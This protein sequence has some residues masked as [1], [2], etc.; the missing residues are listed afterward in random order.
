[1]IS[2]LLYF[3]FFK[4]NFDLQETNGNIDNISV[5]DLF[6]KMDGNKLT[7]TENENILLK[8]L[9]NNEN[10]TSQT[11]IP[12]NTVELE[13]ILNAKGAL[14]ND[15]NSYNDPFDLELAQN[16]RKSFHSMENL[17]SS[18]NFTLNLNN[19]NNTLNNNIRPLSPIF[20]SNNIEEVFGEDNS[21]SS[22]VRKIRRNLNKEIYESL[23]D[24]LDLESSQKKVVNQNIRNSIENKENRLTLNIPNLKESLLKKETNSKNKNSNNSSF[25]KTQNTSFSK[26]I[27]FQNSD[28]SSHFGK[29]EA[30][31]LKSDT[32][33]NL[34]N[35]QHIINKLSIPKL[36]LEKV[37]IKEEMLLS[38]SPSYRKKAERRGLQTNYID[39]SNNKSNSDSE[40]KFKIKRIRNNIKA[41]NKSVDLSHE[42][43]NRVNFS[44]N[45]IINNNMQMRIKE[46]ASKFINNICPRQFVS[47]IL[48]KHKKSNYSFYEENNNN[49]TN[50]NISYANANESLKLKK[51]DLPKDFNENQENEFFKKNCKK[52]MSNLFNNHKL[53]NLLSNPNIPKNK[54]FKVLQIDTK[55]L[56]SSIE[57]SSVDASSNN[58]K[59]E[60]IN[61][62]SNFLNIIAPA[63]NINFY[64]SKEYHNMK[65]TDDISNFPNKEKKNKNELRMN[66]P[67]IFSNNEKENAKNNNETLKRNKLSKKIEQ[68]IL[69]QN[70]F[71]PNNGSSSLNALFKK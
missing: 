28:V 19:N 21:S 25:N 68:K 34:S 64:I 27:N 62:S 22:S 60:L 44:D 67:E 9:K 8:L 24:T 71:T 40:E 12:R 31:L 35:N 48:K 50:T 39:F 59:K 37:I 51:N 1:M 4:L 18:K 53:S 57:S 38:C 66:I 30:D 16:K 49:K 46:K 47:G 55:N 65:E 11:D 20:V 7:A 26:T 23:A 17:L 41:N 6:E 36:N 61:N 52:K 3:F 29:K 5:C 2:F 33:N 54:P 45:N 63:N 13:E 58:E 10:N 14:N 42:N 32:L 15:F 69:K 56:N 70:F 43:K